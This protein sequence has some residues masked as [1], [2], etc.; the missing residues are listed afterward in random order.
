MIIINKTISL[1]TGDGL[2]FCNLTAS[3]KKF[4]EDSHI[5]NG[6]V[7]IFTKHTTAGLRVNE[8]EK[9]L[10]ED[11]HLFLEKIAPK[12][13]KYLHDDIHLRDCPP[14]ERL[15]GHAHLKSLIL[16]TSEIIPVIDGKLVL[17]EWQNLFFIELDGSRK[18]EVIV[19][20]KG[21]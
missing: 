16:N 10:F 8:D 15:N 5:S 11:I 9:R 12:N 18:R 21:E 17:G 6:Q 3:I 20:I 4:V 7:L 19:Q 2:S 1:E 13:A 14:D